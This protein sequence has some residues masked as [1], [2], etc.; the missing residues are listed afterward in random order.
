MS[1]AALTWIA[2]AAL[3]VGTGVVAAFFWGPRG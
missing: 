2:V 3:V 1:P